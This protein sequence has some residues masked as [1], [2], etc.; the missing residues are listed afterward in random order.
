MHNQGEDKDDS[1]PVQTQTLR[2]A[3]LLLQGKLL[4]LNSLGR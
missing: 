1:C 3:L 4:R 2:K